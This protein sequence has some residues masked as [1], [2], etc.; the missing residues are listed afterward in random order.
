M[1]RFD[2]QLSLQALS[3][4][5]IWISHDVLRLIAEDVDMI[6]VVLHELILSL[7]QDP[8]HAK[9]TVYVTN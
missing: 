3:L 5:H 2:N 4:S 6:R 9:H 7:L 8:V 1:I